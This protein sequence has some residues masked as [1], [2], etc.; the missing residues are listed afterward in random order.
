[1]LILTNSL[2]YGGAERV[3]S[4]IYPKLSEKYNMHLALLTRTEIINPVEGDVILLGSEEKKN[5][6]SYAFELVSKIREIK[7]IIKREKIDIVMSFLPVPDLLNIIFCGKAKRIINIRVKLDDGINDG[8]SSKLKYYLKKS[9]YKKAE[10]SVVVSEE[11]KNDMISIFHMKDSLID[12]IYNPYLLDEMKR[13]S[14]ETVSK[15]IEDIFDNN[16]VVV[17]VGRLVRAK[18]FQYLIPAFKKAF[19]DEDNVKLLI[20]GEGDYREHLSTIIND[21]G[22]QDK[23]ILVG[24]VKNPY[25]YLKN[26]SM[27]VLSSMSEGFPN[28]LVEAM[29]LGIPVV[30]TDCKSGPRE[31]L[32]EN[33]DMSHKCQSMEQADYG[34]LVPDFCEDED[35]SERINVLADAMGWLM[36]DEAK[37]A[38]YSQKALERAQYFTLDKC[39]DKYYK[40]IDKYLADEKA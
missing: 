38:Y 8:L 27:F 9:L 33:P 16:R 14:R 26:A 40:V 24:G 23:V 25:K 2:G 12:V 13:K 4:L 17:A 21:S 20:L 35:N 1:V 18:G 36:Q 15:D 30:S 39:I 5:R 22:L 29:C 32:Y 7:R 3:I 11:I 10:G 31:I 6:F 19:Y 34:T 37:R 28:A